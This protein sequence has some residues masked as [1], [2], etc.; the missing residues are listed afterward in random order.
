PLNSKLFT[1][2]YV[3]KS[4]LSAAELRNL[5]RRYEREL[6]ICQAAAKVLAH[7]AP[8]QEELKR[9]DKKFLRNIDRCYRFWELGHDLRD[10]QMAAKHAAGIVKGVKRLGRASTEREPGVDVAD[11]V[12]D[13]VNLLANMLKRVTL[14]TELAPLPGITADSTELVQVWTNIIKNACDAM[15]QAATPQPTVTIT[16]DVYHAEG[17]TL[18]PEDYIRVSISNNGPEIPPEIREKIFQPNFTTKKQ[19]LDFG[20]GLGLA[21]VR[22]V[23]D[24]YAGTIALESKEGETTFTICLP[25]N[26]LLQPQPVEST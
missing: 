23:V 5:S 10:M 22:R 8:N 25:V 9:Y 21:I 16:A 14:R 7:L 20:L 3:D 6:G 15:Q 19:G 17:I 1:L 12:Q 13:A 26:P 4:H 11:T 2:G 18:L 24:S